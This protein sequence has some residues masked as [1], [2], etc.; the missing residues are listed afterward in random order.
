M[1]THSPYISG[2]IKVLSLIGENNASRHQ[3]GEEYVR[4]VRQQTHEMN[5]AMNWPYPMHVDIV[6]RVRR[7]SAPDLFTNSVWPAGFWDE[8]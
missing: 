1:N 4:I 8:G 6:V 2:Q 3:H 5:A 7:K